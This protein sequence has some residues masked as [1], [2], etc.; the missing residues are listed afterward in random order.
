MVVW[1]FLFQ[2][3]PGRREVTATGGVKSL[4]AQACRGE[5]RQL[6]RVFLREQVMTDV[7]AILLCMHPQGRGPANCFYA[8]LST[9][10]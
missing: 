1:P 9:T 5:G 4:I 8:F 6:V 10:S 3:S 2:E 7:T